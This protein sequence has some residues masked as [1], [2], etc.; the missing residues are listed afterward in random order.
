MQ[1]VIIKSVHVKCFEQCVHS[2]CLG[3]G[4]TVEIMLRREGLCQIEKD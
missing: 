3:D 4:E 1:V 2:E